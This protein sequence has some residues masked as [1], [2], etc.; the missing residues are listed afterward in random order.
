MAHNLVCLH[1]CLQILKPDSVCLSVSDGSLLPIFAH[2]LGSKKVSIP[3]FCFSLKIHK[4]RSASK[5]GDLPSPSIMET[6]N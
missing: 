1:V 5:P 4:F 6:Q 2:L 3:C